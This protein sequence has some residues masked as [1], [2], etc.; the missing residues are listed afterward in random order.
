MSQ[1]NNT[2]PFS[3]VSDV[4]FDITPTSFTVKVNG[5]VLGTALENEPFT[6]Y[7]T[8]ASGSKSITMHSISNGQYTQ[9]NSNNH[10]TDTVGLN[11]A[12][13]K[14]SFMLDMCSG[15]N[16]FKGIGWDEDTFGQICNTGR[17]TF[18]SLQSAGNFKACIQNVMTSGGQ[19]MHLVVRYNTAVV[20]SEPQ[21]AGLCAPCLYCYCCDQPAS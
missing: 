3:N 7:V 21:G 20:H 18:F 12:G 16:T 15:S 2:L 9:G 14:S 8:Q 13:G 1:I 19:I 17:S 6:L 11:I 5:N 10:N 4:T